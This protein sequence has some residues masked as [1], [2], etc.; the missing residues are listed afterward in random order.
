MA[1]QLVQDIVLLDEPPIERAVQLLVEEQKIVAEGAGAAG[2]A[3]LLAQPERFRDRRVGIVIGG[4]NI[5]SRLLASILM[6]GLIRDGRLVRLRVEITDMP[7]TL[8]TVAGLIAAA[9]G[10]IVEVYHH[11]MFHDVSVKLTELD[12][13]VETRNADHVREIVE[14]LTGAEFPARRLG[15]A[16]HTDP[17]A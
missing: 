9:G 16:S 8:S 7:G 10:N 2:L 14:R 1:R 3:A 6:R 12:V 13:E 5:D 15:T 17:S 11:R 4:G